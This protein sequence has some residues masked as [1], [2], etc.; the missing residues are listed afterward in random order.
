MLI[1]GCDTDPGRQVP[2]LGLEPADYDARE[3]RAFR[4]L[5]AALRRTI[6]T[7]DVASLGRVATASARINQRFLPKAVLPELLELCRRLGGCGVQVA[8]SGTVAG[9][10]FDARQPKTD[11]AVRQCLAEIAKLGLPVTAVIDTTAAPA[12]TGP[13][14]VRV[15]A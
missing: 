5:R 10:I 1:V 12:P 7:G 8:H 11:E 3:K 13:V 15:P 9:L 4:V 2:T 14:E 6:A